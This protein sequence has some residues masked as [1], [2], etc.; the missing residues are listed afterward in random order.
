MHAKNGQGEFTENNT[1]ILISVENVGSQHTS[2][3]AFVKFFIRLKEVE[4]FMKGFEES[5]LS[6]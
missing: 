4:R 1:A 2:C 6:G 5:K 3:S